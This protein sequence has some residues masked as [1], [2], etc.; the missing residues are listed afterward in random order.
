MLY[1]N[2][3]TVKIRDKRGRICA[4]AR[5]GA[6]QMFPCEE[7]ESPSNR[8]LGDQARYS[9]GTERLVGG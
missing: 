5:L 9:G 3:G 8:G 7:R 1:A 4:V 2:K 6:N